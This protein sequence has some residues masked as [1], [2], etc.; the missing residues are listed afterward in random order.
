MTYSE[1]L[2]YM[3]WDIYKQYYRLAKTYD[4][5]QRGESLEPLQSS[6]SDRE[7]MERTTSAF[8]RKEYGRALHQRRTLDQ[9]YYS[10]SDTTSRDH[11]QTVSKWTGSDVGADGKASATDDSFIIM[12]DQLWCWDLGDTVISCFPSHHSHYQDERNSGIRDLYQSL[13]DIRC[14]S[15]SELYCTIIK[16]AVTHLDSQWNRGFLDWIEIYR[17]VTSKKTANH[18]DCFRDFHREYSNGS[19][20]FNDKRELKLAL[21]VA[22]II[23]EL[24]IIMNLLEKQLEVVTSLGKCYPDAVEVSARVADAVKIVEEHIRSVLTTV[25]EIKTEAEATYKGLPLSFFTA[26]FGQNVSEITGD[27]SNPSWDLWKVGTCVSGSESFEHTNVVV[28]APAH[29]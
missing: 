23:D 17:W 29:Y 11:D 28:S 14:S 26:Y 5:F 27:D 15:A 22:D 13:E 24:K 21:E 12:V 9:F 20:A 1:Q 25:K 10:S 16:Q 8:L 3:N 19:A 18:A 2:P 4:Q 6:A 7:E